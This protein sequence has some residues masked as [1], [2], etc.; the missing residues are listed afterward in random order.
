MPLR[1]FNVFL[2][3]LKNFNLQIA[4]AAVVCSEYMGIKHME[5]LRNSYFSGVIHKGHMLFHQQSQLNGDTL[6]LC[7][8]SVGHLQTFWW[9]LELNI[10]F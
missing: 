7:V 2:W 1:L 9:Q 3:P 8:L 10:Y 5:N 4:T 6:N